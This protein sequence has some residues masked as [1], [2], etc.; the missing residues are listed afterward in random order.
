MRDFQTGKREAPAF[1][2]A[3]RHSIQS[4]EETT[5]TLITNDFLTS[6]ADATSVVSQHDFIKRW[7][8]DVW[9]VEGADD[10]TESADTELGDLEKLP[11]ASPPETEQPAVPTKPVGSSFP[12]AFERWETLSAHWEGLTAFWIRRLQRNEEEINGQPIMQQMARQI[13]DL[14]AAETNLFHAVVEFQRLRASSERKFQRWFFDTRAEQE[15]SREDGA[16]LE[17][18]LQQEQQLRA[19]SERKFQ[20]WFFETRAEQE[21]SREDGAKLEEKLRQERQLREAVTKLLLDN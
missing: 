7:I 11:T 6:G 21:R 4:D 17:E 9:I 1:S 10:T 15:R 19:S 14:A 8:D 3:S 16:K 2:Q 5:W 20:R 12:H 18:K 13:T